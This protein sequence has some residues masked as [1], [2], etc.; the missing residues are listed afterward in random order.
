MIIGP[1]QSCV[2]SGTSNSSDTAAGKW[3]L[4]TR[5]H[6]SHSLV[7]GCK[8]SRA[9]VQDEFRALR[10]HALP[11]LRVQPEHPRD[12]LHQGRQ[13]L[14]L[15]LGAGEVRVAQQKLGSCILQGREMGQEWQTRTLSATDQTHI[16]D[17]YS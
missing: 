6:S 5:E 8:S 10:Q 4:L 13:V 7:L 12:V 14:E 9:A 1:E 16:H 17:S 2:H 3:L 15:V 11:L